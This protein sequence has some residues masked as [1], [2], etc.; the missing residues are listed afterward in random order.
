MTKINRREALL[1]MGGLFGAGL[2]GASALNAKSLSINGITAPEI[3][4]GS[5]FTIAHITDVHITDKL[6]AEKWVS[7]CFNHLQSQSS[8]PQFILNTGDVIMDTSKA[9]KASALSQWKI[10][11]RV[12]KQENSLPIHTCLGNHDIWGIRKSKDPESKDPLYGKKMSLE[13]LGM[14]KLYYS[15]DQGGWHFVMLDGVMADWKKSQWY[16]ELDKE[17]FEWLKKDLEA[18]PKDRPVLICSH[19][20][21]LQVCSMASL[22]PD[23]KDRYEF[24][25]T[26]M[27]GDARELIDLFRKHPNVKLCYSGHI[28]RQDRVELAGVTYICGGAVCGSKWKKLGSHTSEPGY[29]TITLHPDGR[30]DAQYH[31]FGWKYEG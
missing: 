9:D 19:I 15:F 22:E 13:H 4:A 17:Q 11:N 7:K 1:R 2:M 24:T 25:H 12:V 20:P 30:F 28:H 16:G 31:T 10:W 27:M 29:S 3:P 26:A 8:K 5:P 21:I 23:E 14:D 6:N 18:T